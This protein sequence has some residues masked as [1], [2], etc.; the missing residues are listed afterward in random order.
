MDFQQLLILKNQPPRQG[1][2]VL[3]RPLI[4]RICLCHLQHCSADTADATVL[5]AATV[6][7]RTPFRSVGELGLTTI[8]LISS[9]LIKSRIMLACSFA[10]QLVVLLTIL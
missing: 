5:P 2:E 7:A 10:S 3:Q 8:T 9:S 1:T 4:R 6:S